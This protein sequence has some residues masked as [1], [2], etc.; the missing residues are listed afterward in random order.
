[1]LWTGKQVFSL[2]L[3][4]NKDCPVKANLRAKGKAYS[5]GEDMCV[6]DSCKFVVRNE[7][8]VILEFY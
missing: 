3:K 2:I 7:A 4:P 6:N 1:M 5:K 8:F